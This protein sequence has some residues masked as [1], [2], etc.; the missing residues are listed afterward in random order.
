MQPAKTLQKSERPK[1]RLA[2]N[3]NFRI[4]QQQHEQL[5]GSKSATSPRRVHPN[6]FAYKKK[7]ILNARI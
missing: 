5:S 2:T 6:R 4:V 1:P 3:G 7:Q